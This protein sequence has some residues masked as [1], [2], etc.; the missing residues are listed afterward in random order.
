M[1]GRSG[2]T[3]GRSPPWGS[4]PDPS[5]SPG[6]AGETDFGPIEAGNRDVTNIGPLMSISTVSRPDR[7]AP[8]GGPIAGTAVSEG[9]R[10]SAGRSGA[11]RGRATRAGWERGQPAGCDRGRAGDPLRI[12]RGAA[13]KSGFAPSVNRL[14]QLEPRWTRGDPRCRMDLSADPRTWLKFHHGSVEM[15]RKSGGQDLPNGVPR[16]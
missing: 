11:G 3:C 13:R 8:T 5:R 4:G 12:G 15:G 2:P 1:P 14:S 7:L 16:G 10:P 9:G 6:R